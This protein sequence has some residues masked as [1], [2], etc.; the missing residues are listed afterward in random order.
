MKQYIIRFVKYLLAFGVLYVGMMWVMH[1]FD[2]WAQFITF[3][4]RMMMLFSN[5]W[6][7]W[8][9]VVGIVLLA[10]TY[11]YFGF[12]KRTFEGDIEV[13]NE[14]I[15]RAA[16]MVGLVLVHEEEGLM[17]FHT[18][19]VRRFVMLFEDE[20]L[21]RQNGNQIEVEGLRR[22]AA[23]MAFDAERFITNKRRVE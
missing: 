12:V 10:A 18:K 23:R 9:M 13:D 7:G 11:P 6:N 2:S 16:E 3:E 14:Q 21:V 4:E 19:G 8:G 17:V 5:G 22:L 1:N 15:T 20:V